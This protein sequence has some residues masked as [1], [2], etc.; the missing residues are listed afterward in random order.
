MFMV[1]AIGGD[2]AL[3]AIFQ[4]IQAIYS[5][6]R[7]VKANKEQ[8][9]QL[10]ERIRIIE[11]AVKSHLA[12]ASNT[13]SQSRNDP[14][15]IALLRLQNVLQDCHAEI[16]QF[17]ENKYMAC[18]VFRQ[19]I[20]RDNFAGLHE[21]LDRSLN[22]LQTA[23]VIQLPQTVQVAQTD[24]IKAMKKDLE[25][26]AENVKLLVHL[27][28]NSLD[29]GLINQQQAEKSFSQRLQK[30][31]TILT[32]FL[33]SHGMATVEEFTDYIIAANE[34]KLGEEI[35]KGGFGIVYA[36]EWNFSKVGVKKLH[37]RDS[38][39]TPRARK[40]FKQEA[41]MLRYANHRNVVK[42]FGLV[43]NGA[44]YMLVME[45][46]ERK[47]L[48]MVINEH[49]DDL[50][51]EI[52]AD[53]SRQIALGLAY[54]HRQSVIHCD[55]KSNNILVRNDNSVAIADFGLAKVKQETRNSLT[56]LNGDSAGNGG[57]IAWMAPELFEPGANPSYA[58][59]VYAFSMILFE[60]ADGG[61]PFSDVPPS[62]ISRRVEKGERPEVPSDT[63]EAIA[64]IMRQCWAAEP[65]QRPRCDELVVALKNID[66][67][68]TLAPNSDEPKK[69]TVASSSISSGSSS[70]VATY[71]PSTHTP[72]DTLLAEL[73]AMTALS[74]P[75]L[76][77]SPPQEA[78]SSTDI[79]ATP[80]DRGYL[81]RQP[82]PESTTK[83]VRQPEPE[84]APKPVR[85]PKPLPSPHRPPTPQQLPNPSK[86]YWDALIT[87]D[88]EALKSI[89]SANLI[90][91]DTPMEGETGLQFACRSNHNSVAIVKILLE[92]GADHER[93]NENGKL[94]IQLSTSVK[95]WRE[96]AAIMAKPEGG[97]F[98]A[99]EN[100][101]DVNARLILGGIPSKLLSQ[102]KK[103]TLNDLE[104][105]VMPLHVAASKG[106][107]A[108]CRVFLEAG[109]D[110]QCRGQWGMTPLILAAWMGHLDVTRLLI[111]KGADVEGKDHYGKTSL[112]CAV[113]G[114]HADVV[115]FLLDSGAEIE[116]RNNLRETPLIYAAGGGHLDVAQLLVERGAKIDGRN[117]NG[118][119]PIHFAASRGRVD[120]LRFLLEAG[121]D[122][123][124]RDKTQDT[125]L[126]KAVKEG[127]LNVVK[128]LVD[129][130]ADIEGTG[131]FKYT[132]LHHAASKGPV[133]M[134]RFLL[135]RGVDINARNVSNDTPLIRAA[136]TGQFDVVKLLVEKGADLR[137]KGD[138][139]TAHYWASGEAKEVIAAALQ[140]RPVAV[141][142]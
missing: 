141:E 101:N 87:G 135:E 125:P 88:T 142:K 137:A 140:Q 40:A 38:D 136:T 25:F 45:Y 15:I 59:D 17:T 76:P 90:P 36:G 120:V 68:S 37:C 31:Q 83:P 94:P 42:F 29:A 7:E 24:C 138:L 112:H 80:P 128:L 49:F 62:A 16:Q 131:S 43:K 104:T 123:E 23:F 78:P 81:A 97:L 118:D 110:I 111:E 27:F 116:C 28:L 134:V 57:T 100:G 52:K 56:N 139:G 9:T 47:C 5:I 21:A 69:A 109:G 6:A 95:V 73:D 85:Q 115:R 55:L 102:R 3:G 121:A 48:R 93:R 34:L 117:K 107:E 65:S 127:H 77:T 132:P 11:A 72:M 113:F 92:F 18:K 53:Y 1:G 46:F 63:P 84:S 61:Y 126:I 54:L 70:A 103:M 32:A 86:K 114:G 14:K 39:L 20:S 4:V 35:G 124:C 41:K 13:V 22:D 58:T 96:F 10:V 129:K 91:V 64:T 66:T 106:H 12:P 108:V 33:Q 44:D 50:S 89:L 119:A 75:L 98:D 71:S 30:E 82:K 74:S 99:A 130:G 2:V 79:L 60:L 105:T 8:C 122:I 19:L 67:A 51:W 26:L 133:A